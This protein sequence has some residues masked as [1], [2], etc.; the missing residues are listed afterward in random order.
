MPQFEIR[1]NTKRVLAVE[2]DDERSAVETAEH[3]DF[4]DWDSTDSP[5]SVRRLDA[6]AASPDVREMECGSHVLRIDVRLFRSQR[7]LL[8]KI[9]D[10]ARKGQPYSP[11]PEDGP[12]L[13]GLLE[14]TDAL[15]DAAAGD[16]TEVEG[17]VRELL[18]HARRVGAPEDA[19]DDLVHDTAQECGL[20]DLNELEDPDDQEAHIG[21]VE[22]SAS[23]INNG[24]LEDQL[25]FLLERGVS[26]ERIRKALEA[27]E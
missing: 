19:L 24:G 14:L 27:T 25:R 15:F 12:L 3:V 1:C 23:R 4:S 26:P 21:S 18:E 20:G 5:Y 22:E 8:T 17:Q 9:A 16:G 10:L 11:D 2:A 6:T 13:D 7:E